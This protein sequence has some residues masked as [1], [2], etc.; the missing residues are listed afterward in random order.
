MYSTCNLNIICMF[1]YTLD[2]TGHLIDMWKISKSEDQPILSDSNWVGPGEGLG[3]GG[4]H[5]VKQFINIKVKSSK[6][7][8]KVHAKNNLVSTCIS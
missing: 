3:G 8:V 6:E 7:E 1:M 4:E 5:A 2:C